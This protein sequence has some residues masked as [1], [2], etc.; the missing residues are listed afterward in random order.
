MKVSWTGP[1]NTDDCLI[2]VAAWSGSTVYAYNQ[3]IGK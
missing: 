1:F 2:E 3:R